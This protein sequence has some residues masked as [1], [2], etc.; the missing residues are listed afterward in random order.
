MP[1]SQQN[2]LV[3]VEAERAETVH[4]LLRAVGH[5]TTSFY[6]TAAGEASGTRFLVYFPP[7]EPHKNFSRRNQAH[8]KDLSTIGAYHQR[9][10]DTG[11]EASAAE[12]TMQNA[13]GQRRPR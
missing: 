8:P 5:G 12:I 9:V 6:P 4:L 11:F 2:A 13:G 1:V 7:K 3:H 10:N